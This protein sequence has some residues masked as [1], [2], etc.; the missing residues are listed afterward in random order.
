MTKQ[1]K[2]QRSQLAGGIGANVVDG[3]LG[4]AIRTWKQDLKNSGILK[5]IYK[6]R[7]FVSKSQLRKEIV[8][9]AKYRT[10]FENSSQNK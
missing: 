6:K 8:D 5:E 7:E 4:L 3:D 9:K 2:K 10:K 1:E